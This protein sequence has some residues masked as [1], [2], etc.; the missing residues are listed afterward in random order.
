MHFTRLKITG[1][2]SFVEPTDFFIEPGLTGIVGPN[3]CGKSNIVESL[4]WAMGENSAKRLRGGDMDD[5]IFS[6]SAGRPARNIAEV[7]I[8]MDNR[9]RTAPAEFN[10]DDEIEIS[11]RIE[12]GFGSDYRI[13]GRAV[14]QKDVQLLFAD[15]ATGAHSTSIVSQGRVNALIQAKPQ[16]RRQVL[17]EAAGTTGLHARRHEAELKLKASEANIA[18]VDDQLRL[19]GDQLKGLKTQTR[20]ASRYRNLG[21]LIRRTEAALLYLEAKQAEV[22]LR[23]SEDTLAE[24]EVAVRDLTSAVAQIGT[25]RA[26]SASELPPLR[27]AE[28]AA[29]AILQRILLERETL[30]REAARIAQE[31]E[32]IAAR[33]TQTVNDQAREEALGADAQAALAR[34]GEEDVRIAA[35]LNELEGSAPRLEAEAQEVASFAAE[36]EKQVQAETENLAHAR[37]AHAEAARRVQAAEA[38]EEQFAARASALKEKLQKLEE[39]L[40][41]LPNLALAQS[42][43]E[44]CET[45]LTKK[46]AAAGKARETHGAAEIA[47]E[48]AREQRQQA[49]AERMRGE[50]EEEALQKLLQ[51]DEKTGTPLSDLVEVTPGFEA[52]LAAALSDGLAATLDEAAGLFWK[53]LPPFKERYELPKGAEALGD[54]VKVPSALRR[55]MSQIGLVEDE[56]A[57][58]RLAEQLKPGQILVTRAGAAWRWDGF[59]QRVNAVTPAAQRLQQR[60]RLHEVQ[61]LNKAASARADVAE[62][63][64]LAAIRDEEEKAKAESEAQAA[65]HQAFEALDEARRN[66]S[67]QAQAQGENLSQVSHLREAVQACEADR[68]ENEKEKQAAQA[69]AG[70]LAPLSALE[71]TLAEAQSALAERRQKAAEKQAAFAGYAREKQGM[72]E[73]QRALGEERQSWTA[74][75]EGAAVRIKELQQRAAELKAEQ[76]SLAEKPAALDVQRQELLSKSSVAEAKRQETADIL[77]AAENRLE[78]IEKKAR[79]QEE[80]LSASKQNR[81]RAEEQMYRAQHSYADLCKKSEEGW[82]CVPDKLLAAAEIAEGEELPS[83]DK[84]QQDYARYVRER[85][86]MGP[87]NLRAEIEGD[88]LEAQIEKLSGEK[89]DLAAAIGK[90]RQGILTL[91]RE[92]RDRLQIAFDEVNKHFSEL[93]TRL[94][95][96]GKAHLKLLE[97]DDPLEAGLEIYAS[98]PGKRLQALTLLSGGEQALTAIA[99]LFAI[100]LVNPSPI[101]VLDEVDAPLDESNVDRFCSLVR[102]MAG[103]GRTRFL[104]I[105]HHRLSMA[106]M[107][108]LYGVTMAEKGVSQLVSVDLNQALAIRDRE[109]GVGT[110][111]AS[112]RAA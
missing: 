92:A 82:H 23:L 12:R 2:K 85:E 36:Q 69:S 26:E 25:S 90:L 86:H 10:H 13:N 68:S 57:G 101:C 62:T 110:P 65:L 55:A 34:L 53:S 50:A 112:A 9:S 7:V 48:A 45:D 66:F 40:A 41:A 80:A 8:A 16:E 88:E 84:L 58:D 20:Q 17:E 38:R 54:Y 109:E 5:V 95:G 96:G 1:F 29:A 56:A 14:R 100:F 99:L 71:K 94:F 98:P 104:I 19:M 24:S 67:N 76:Q 46:Q 87:V 32:A 83:L 18:R 79:A 44:A 3:G 72:A 47:L 6:G 70:G 89:N 73:R 107:D 78:G 93:F 49:W 15:Q 75:A 103:E 39:T 4:R 35:R 106:R 60:N 11:R 31:Q 105:T 33:L 59:C 21:E 52:G 64:L 42:L 22:S 108:R 61:D 97:S 30:E 102:D 81:V 43:V 111:S 37:A 91:N 77:L 27:H 63:A 74:R 28:A 51:Q